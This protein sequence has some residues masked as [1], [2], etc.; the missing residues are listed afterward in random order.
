MCEV[1]F[2]KSKVM[3]PIVKELLDNN[4]RVRITVTGMSMY[5]FLRG[6]KDCVELSKRVYSEINRGD[7]VLVSLDGE[8]Q[9]ILHRILH[10]RSN[11]FYMGGD[12]QKVLEGPLRPEQI[13]A[14]VAGIWRNERFI[15][16]NNLGWR[17]LS[18]LWMIF[19]P[20]RYQII[21]SYR[22]TKRFMTLPCNKRRLS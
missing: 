10:K 8:D 21:R 5:P 19:Y 2:V 4:M 7:I 6:N 17:I 12:A 1:K 15:S 9:Y 18:D 11:Y 20:F 22:A 3:F 14:F 16:C 13:V